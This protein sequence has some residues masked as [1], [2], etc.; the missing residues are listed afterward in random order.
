MGK[1][2]REWVKPDE[3]EEMT[4]KLAPLSGGHA[5]DLE[6]KFHVCNHGAPRQQAEILE[7]HA[8]ILA[9]LLLLIG[10]ELL[11]RG[12]DEARLEHVLGRYRDRQIAKLHVELGSELL[13]FWIEAAVHAP[14]ILAVEIAHNR[15]EEWQIEVGEPLVQ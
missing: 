10:A 12:F 11:Q 4:R 6:R 13:D 9:R 3:V 8:G 1:M 14:Q 7:H 15:R 2:L 5:I